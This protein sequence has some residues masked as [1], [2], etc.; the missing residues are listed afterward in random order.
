VSLA[1]AP[2]SSV[3]A[4]RRG[5]NL[6]VFAFA[7]HVAARFLAFSHGFVLAVP[8]FAYLVL[9]RGR[10]A[11][12]ATIARRMIVLAVAA[13]VFDACISAQPDVDGEIL[14]LVP[15][16]RALPP[17]L[18]NL[19]FVPALIGVVL[20]LLAASVA[21]LAARTGSVAGTVVADA[22][23]AVSLAAIGFVAIVAVG[24]AA[25]T[26]AR[27]PVVYPALVGAALAAGLVAVL[28]SLDWWTI[29]SPGG[30][31][32]AFTIATIA[33]AAAVAVPISL[34]PFGAWATIPEHAGTAFADPL[35]PLPLTAAFLRSLAPLCPL[36]FGL[37]L[38][39]AI[40]P[41]PAAAGLDRSSFARLVLCCYAVLAGVVVLVPVG[42]VLAWWTFGLLRARGGRAAPARDADPL[43]PSP[44]AR[45]LAAIPLALAFVAVEVLL[46]LSSETRYL[47][48]VHTPF[49]VLEAAGFLAVIIA[50]LVLP[51]F[52]FAACSEEL[53][54]ESGLGKGLRVGAW[55][56]AC[57][58]P[59]W[60][61]RSDSLVTA[62]SVAL[63]TGL[64]YAVLG[65]VTPAPGALTQRGLRILGP[66]PR[67]M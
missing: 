26:L 16:L 47:R 48:E 62:V 11:R 30:R 8:M 18:V 45:G 55:A 24:F 13:D 59:A 60:F 51:A 57:S 29:P 38:V 67:P 61:L 20:A 1:F 4:L 3:D 41:D 35:S 58:L 50:S 43:V 2:F 10:N 40:R 36:A 12:F 17:A 21:R 33:F 9:S 49:V 46:L 53:A 5:L 23:N 54:G 7:P 66:T 6:P 56:I 32:R 15:A 25:G 44:R 34:V 14:D 31:R 27:V 22:A 65:R 63:V 64:F 19:F 28:A 39:A 52:A 37:L 42:F